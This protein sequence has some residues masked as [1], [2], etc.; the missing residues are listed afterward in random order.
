LTL[1]ELTQR[2]ESVYGAKTRGEL[3]RITEDLPERAPG[4]V[5][6]VATGT[7]W[8]VSVFGDVTRSGSW[9]AEGTMRPVSVFGDVDLDLRGATVP[10]GRAEIRATSPFG[11][12]DVL[13][14]SGVE[15]DVSV[16]TLFGSKK[17]AVTEGPR[18]PSTPVL[19]IRAFTLFGSV[20]V[21]TP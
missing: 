20:K 17:I 15:A 11:N 19:R 5:A 8:L 14:P 10:S 6:P 1:E 18:T 16:F 13:V 21:W 3:V 9:R 4:T 12:I 2:I 7:R